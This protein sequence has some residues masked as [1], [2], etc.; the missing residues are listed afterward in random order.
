MC[1]TYHKIK[2]QLDSTLS[3]LKKN[4]DSSLEFVASTRKVIESLK[5][6]MDLVDSTT[7]EVLQISLD[8]ENERLKNSQANLDRYD[9]EVTEY[10]WAMK[11][12]END[13]RELCEHE[14][15]KTGYNH[16]NGNEEFE[17]KHCKRTRG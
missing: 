6:S 16:H 11:L 10:E 14:F 3:K 13:F 8:K 2:T 1:N 9:K 4:R 12:L 7:K 17:C 5:I 15:E